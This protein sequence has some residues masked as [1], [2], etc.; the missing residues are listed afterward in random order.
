MKILP[1]MGVHIQ[2]K[3]SPKRTIPQR[4][5]LNAKLPDLL[6]SR[7]SRKMEK[8]KEKKKREDGEEREQIETDRWY[9][10]KPG[11][12]IDALR[13]GLW[14]GSISKGKGIR[15]LIFRHRR[16]RAW[17]ESRGKKMTTVQIVYQIKHVRKSKKN[18]NSKNCCAHLL[19]E[20]CPLILSFCKSNE[21]DSCFWFLNERI[22]GVD[23]RFEL[24]GDRRWRYADW[25]EWWR[26]RVVALCLFLWRRQCHE[27]LPNSPIRTRVFWS[28]VFGRDQQRRRRHCIQHAIMKHDKKPKI[29]VNTKHEPCHILNT[30]TNFQFKK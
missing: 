9:G 25:W 29:R 5:E 3:S 20:G 27:I 23:G 8:K 24:Q 7:G 26:L 21:H 13:A 10:L 18:R 12:D 4:R 30:K 15:I 14:I 6:F 19:I 16:F 11:I 22:G 17:V 28:N 1:E 2:D